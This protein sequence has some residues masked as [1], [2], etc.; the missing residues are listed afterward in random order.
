MRALHEAH[1]LML[2][3]PLICSL[4]VVSQ[5]AFG[6]DQIPDIAVKQT[7]D[8]FSIDATVEVRGLRHRLQA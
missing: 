3:V 2:V 4:L 8:T 7:G 1:L 6:N 5:A